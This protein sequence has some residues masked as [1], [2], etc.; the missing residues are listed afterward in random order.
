MKIR[1]KDIKANSMMVITLSLFVFMTFISSM[2]SLGLPLA[3]FIFLFLCFTVMYILSSTGEISTIIAIP[4]LLSVFQNVYLGYFSPKL[5]STNIQ[6]LTVLNFLLACVIFFYLALSYQKTYTGQVK[7]FNLF[8]CLVGYTFISV[9][10][11]NEINVISIISSLRNVISIFVF[12]FIGYY[13]SRRVELRKFENIMLVFGLIVIIVGIYDVLV[14]DTFWRELNITDLWT[15]KGIRV[16]ASGLPTNFYSSETINGERIRRMA[17][18]F[19][20]P[21]NLGAFLFAAFSIAWHKKNKITSFFMVIGMILTVSKGA[22]LGLLIFTCV[23][24]FYYLPKPVFIS[25]MAGAGLTGVGF[26][27]YAFKTSANSV[28]LHISGLVAAF[29]G[30]ITNPLGS[31]IG[32]N[33]V[34]AR[35]FSGFSANSEITETGLGMIIGQLGIV[36][37]LVYTAFFWYLVKYCINTK[38]KRDRVL[39]LTLVLSIVVNIFFNEVA[40]SPNSCAIYFIVV[41][42]IISCNNNERPSI[43]NNKKVSADRGLM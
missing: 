32:S 29:R 27:I 21:V 11:L 41:G 14:G 35:Q 39:A 31:G 12:F 38:D 24:A 42:H 10:F 6:V 40:L 20:D 2:G 15:K 19:A 3:F 7:V 8:I 33:G 43:F 5:S 34:L 9:V 30:L 26:L 4:V 18:T 1:K 17:S 37:F 28:F 13:S 25:V 23:Y 36:G 16:Q 22:W